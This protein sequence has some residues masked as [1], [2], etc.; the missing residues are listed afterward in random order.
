MERRVWTLG[1]KSE[2]A[3]KLR[4]RI[5]AHWAAFSRS[6]NGACGDLRVA[7]RCDTIKSQQEGY[8]EENCNACIVSKSKHATASSKLKFISRNRLLRLSRI[9]E[10]ETNETDDDDDEKGEGEGEGEGV[11]CPSRISVIESAEAG[12]YEKDWEDKAFERL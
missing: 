8:C 10:T 12:R 4:H 5:K 7:M 2:T 1:R 3:I 6:S 9:A 11:S